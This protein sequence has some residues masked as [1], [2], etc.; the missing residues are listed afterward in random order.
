MQQDADGRDVRDEL[1]DQRNPGGVEVHVGYVGLEIE[2]RSSLVG[3]VV[4]VR[5]VLRED[6]ANNGKVSPKFCS[7]RYTRPAKLRSG[8]TSAS[9]GPEDYR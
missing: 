5:S 8:G 6:A 3:R 4:E 1:T 2:V 9:L 7:A